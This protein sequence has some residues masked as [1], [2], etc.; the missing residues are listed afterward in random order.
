MMKTIRSIFTIA[1]AA[2][3][4][5]SFGQINTPQPSS[6]GSV[7][8]TVGLTEVTIDYS[9]PK[10][11]GRQIF[12]E[13]ADFLQPFGQLWRTGANSGSVLTLST[14]ATVAGTEVKAGQYLIFSTP[15]KDSWDF[16]LY[17]DLSI[18]GNVGAYDE[19]K[20]VLKT[21]VKPTWTS[22]NTE[23]LTFNI[24]DISEDNTSANIEMTWANVS[25][26]VPFTVNFHENVMKDI[27][28]KMQINPANYTAAA[29]Y[30]L[31]A[32]EKLDMALEY[33]DAYLALDGRD[34]QFWHI[35]TKAK[36]LAALGKKD[37]AI[38]AAQQSY[39]VAAAAPNDFGYKANNEKLIAE[40]KGKK[41]K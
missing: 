14:D 16:M 20:Q 18:G 19:A 6:A 39:D 21:S 11:K 29:N 5:L 34:K 38:A 30:L 27:A 37:E 12:G 2:I 36:I 7:S 41:K 4:T 15:G 28:A 13:G 8:A 23:T 22:S 25:V 1:L 40:L 33:M 3:A 17:S 26:K 32:G 31:A 24:S 10:M 9:R 35:H